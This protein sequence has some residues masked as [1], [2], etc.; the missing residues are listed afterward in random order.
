VTAAATADWDRHD[1]G[2]Y[3]PVP[4]R[5]AD[6]DEVREWCVENCAADFIAVLGQRV[7]F[8]SRVD[9]ALATLW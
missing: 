1:Y 3:I 2:S 6:L 8:Q 7:L 4:I 9:A 5:Y